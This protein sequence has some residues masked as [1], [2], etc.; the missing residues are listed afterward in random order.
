MSLAWLS[1]LKLAR[2]PTGSFQ[3]RT[4]F[5]LGILVGP[6]I[7]NS[8][9]TRAESTTNGGQLEEW[10]LTNPASSQNPDCKSFTLESDFSGLTGTYRYTRGELPSFLV[11][12]KQDSTPL[13][14]GAD[15]QVMIYDVLQGKVFF[16]QNQNV[17]MEVK[18]HYSPKPD[19]SSFT[20][21]FCLYPDV[22]HI[23]AGLRISSEVP[24]T[25]APELSCKSESLGDNKFVAHYN[26]TRNRRILK[27][28]VLFEGSPKPTKLNSITMSMPMR[29]D[30]AA[31][32][33]YVLRIHGLDQAE[34]SQAT[35]FPG[36]QVK[37]IAR[38]LGPA[39]MR[40]QIDDA[41]FERNAKIRK[42][43]RES[44]PESE[45]K[46]E[47]IIAQTR[48]CLQEAKGK[49]QATYEAPSFLRA[50][51]SRLPDS[52]IQ[53]LYKI[54]GGDGKSEKEFLEQYRGEVL[55]KRLEDPGSC[56]QLA[57]DYI[58]LTSTLAQEASRAPQAGLATSWADSLEQ[59]DEQLKGL[60]PGKLRATDLEVSSELKKIFKGF[61]SHMEQLRAGP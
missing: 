26:L 44:S 57:Q 23:Q 33:L 9:G 5:A 51:F 19:Q 4:I 30:S 50:A 25:K 10:L 17:G 16:M 47:E 41:L 29:A 38:D 43:L 55:Q 11:M 24:L 8:E 40:S 28:E 45:R 58:L 6:V 32:M 7:L 61:V 56:K 36:Q 21:G 46:I 20:M 2:S 15:G 14:A 49:I 52:I 35:G 22:K 1:R 18:V 59:I 39:E 31:D 42:L 60:E 37:A 54:K 3:A 34:R 27:A 53:R 48:K 13:F 12:D